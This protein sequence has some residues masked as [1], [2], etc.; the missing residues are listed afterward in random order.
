MRRTAILAAL[1]LA[2]TPLF[3][4]NDVIRK[5]FNVADGGTLH[6]DAGFGSVKIVAGGTGVAVEVIREAHGRKAERR[7]AE[8]KIDFS[9][10][11]NDVVIL[12]AGGDKR[13]QDRDIRHALALARDL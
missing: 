4:A 13:T 8:H 9:Q 12:L 2:A 1:L 5:G 7:M 10:Q 6:L 3:A 11:G